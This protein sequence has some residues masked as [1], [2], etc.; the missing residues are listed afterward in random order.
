M[1]NFVICEDD[2]SGLVLQIKENDT[3]CHIINFNLTLLPSQCC[4]KAY[5]ESCQKVMAEPFVKLVNGF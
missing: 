3:K 1:C 4:L 5:L 2:L